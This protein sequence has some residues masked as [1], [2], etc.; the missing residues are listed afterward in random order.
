MT[1]I[2]LLISALC[3]FVLG[4]VA[5]DLLDVPTLAVVAAGLMLI[6]A[7]MVFKQ[8]KPRK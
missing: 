7:L 1:P 8:R 5:N 4:Y 3:L 6:I 2:D